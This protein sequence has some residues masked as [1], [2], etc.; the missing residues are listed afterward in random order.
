MSLILPIEE[1]RK[2]AFSDPD[3]Q[4]R[5]EQALRLTHGQRSEV[6][7]AVET[8]L[9]GYAGMPRIHRSSVRNILAGRLY[10]KLHGTLS[11]RAKEE[12][13]SANIFA[14]VVEEFAN[15]LKT[16]L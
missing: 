3:L 1:P 2:P 10:R 7:F 14:T 4:N 8:V 15:T 11:R 5:F 6:A 16:S 12:K 9:Y 13:Q